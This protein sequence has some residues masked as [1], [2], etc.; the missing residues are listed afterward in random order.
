MEHYSGQKGQSDIN[1]SKV[2]RCNRL[3]CV[4]I[5]IIIIYVY[6]IT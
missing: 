5:I 3:Y 2:I 1:I 4:I 6:V